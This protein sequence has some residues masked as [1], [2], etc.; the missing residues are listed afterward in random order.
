[1]SYE[2]Y[3]ALAII[4]S[5]AYVSQFQ[6]NDYIGVV[7]YDVGSQTVYNLTKVDQNPDSVRKAASDAIQA[8]SN[9][10]DGG[11][12]NIGSGIQLGTSMLQSASAPRG[13]VLL[14]DGYQNEGPDALSV[15]PSNIPIYS[16]AMGPNS[17]QNLIQT[18]ADRTGGQ[19]YYA[20]YVTDM[21]KIY[22]AIRGQAPNTQLLVNQ[23]DSIQP[24][25]YKLIPAT[26]SAGNHTGQFSVTWTDAQ[27]IYSSDPPTGNRF[28]L[29][30][31]DPNL[32]VLNKAPAIIGDGYAIYNVDNPA[33]GT[34]Y[35]QVEYA[36]YSQNLGMTSG[37]FEYHESGS[38]PVQMELA[39]PKTIRAGDPLTFQARVT[40]KEDPIEDLQIVAEI[41]QPKISVRNALSL[42]RD[43]IV[44]VKLT[45]EQNNE[46]VP[47]ELVKLRVLRRNL[48]P[49]VD[50]LPTIKYPTF[51]ERGENGC[52]V[53]AARDT[54]Q[55]G[56][57]NIQVSVTG[58]AKKSGT[59]FQRTQLVSVF[60]E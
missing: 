34:W 33:P 18:I 7:R 48:L 46:S 35:L 23:L 26:V 43:Q 4:D 12:T 27:L 36:G 16:C 30:L 31:V 2:G 39:V 17:D 58:Y 45:E 32:N 44:P 24:F 28:R 54:M 53:S 51:L 6:P 15:L 56:T 1:M 25:D 5:K 40:D 59:P 13:M 38:S 3:V 21:M 19:Y 14:T 9:L 20:P 41:A 60:V 52:Y 29:S 49:H 47:E 37:A 11:S 50:L 55:S 10:F 22:Q 8:L 42:Y 57:Y